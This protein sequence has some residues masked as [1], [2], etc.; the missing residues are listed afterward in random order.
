VQNKLDIAVQ[1]GQRLLLLNERGEVRLRP[2]RYWLDFDDLG[3]R[4]SVVDHFKYWVQDD[5]YLY[6][7]K[8]VEEASKIKQSYIVLKASKRGNDIANRKLQRRLGPLRDALKQCDFSLDKVHSCFLYITLTYDTKL[9]SPTEASNRIGPDYNRFI[10]AL[11]KTFGKVSQVRSWEY[12]ENGYPHVH[13]L[14]YFHEKSFVYKEHF[15][16]DGKKTYRI[17]DCW[18]E[19]IGGH[20]DYAKKKHVG[21]MWHSNVDIQ[22][23]VDNGIKRLN[24]VLS[25]VVKFK[26]DHVPPDQWNHKELL[27]MSALWY[28]RKRQFAVS[29]G[30]ADDLT[31]R[32]CVIQTDKQT[33]LEGNVITVVRYEFL[34]MVNGR[35]AGIDPTVWYKTYDKPPPFHDLAWQPNR[36]SRSSSVLQGMGFK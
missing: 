10:S 25:Y 20:W 16:K 5:D 35:E 15:D 21:G 1:A 9:C 11:R 19:K 36:P 31:R 26:E 28:H 33:D 24:D 22:A 12:S 18:K 32:C 13:G 27:T 17:M 6:F 14:F 8:T 29:G 2:V 34:G 3:D 4:E 30:F 23:V 7:R